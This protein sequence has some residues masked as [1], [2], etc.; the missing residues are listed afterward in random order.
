MPDVFR[1]RGVDSVF[2]DVRG[3]IA[4]ALEMARDNIK[5]K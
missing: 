2:R 4:H 3:V 5:F 1:R